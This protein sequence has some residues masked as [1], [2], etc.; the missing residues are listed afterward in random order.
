MMKDIAVVMIHGMGDIKEGF[1]DDMREKL[2]KKLKPEVAKR[3]HYEK[4]YYSDILQEPQE[5]MFASMEVEIHK[6]WYASFCKMIYDCTRSKKRMKRCRDLGFIW[7]MLSVVMSL[8]ISIRFLDVESIQQDGWTYLIFSIHTLRPL[9]IFILSILI[10]LFI[11]PFNRIFILELRK[12]MMYNMSDA[13]ALSSKV[14]Q[15]GKPYYDVQKRVCKALKEA[16]QSLTEK[17]KKV[18][19]VAD[20]L[21]AHVISN[22]I[23]D[24][25]NG[26]G[27]FEAKKYP[28]TSFGTL[29][30]SEEEKFLRL[31]N[32]KSFIT[33]GCNIP[34]LVGAHR[35]IEAIATDSCG[36]NFD[37]YNYYD[38]DDIL[39]WPL[40]C[41]PH[42]CNKGSYDEAVSE[43][44]AINAWRG[45]W[46]L[47]TRSWNP[48]CHLEYWKTEEVVDKIAKEIKAIV[49]GN[50]DNGDSDKSTED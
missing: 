49:N 10:L 39:G 35:N 18:I 16:Y 46:G 9:V 21:G 4:I 47:L 17:E 33:T 2:E 23:W 11:N 6:G 15:E 26:K 42:D 24:C 3:V 44:R 36:Y 8:I 31:Q 13:G 41:I 37:W 14:Y 7:I 28:D 27:I 43:D 12:F 5:K 29:E 22:Y 38:K 25:Q 34:L 50:G 19:L 32:M 20:S 1:G 30:L 45:I 48:L 40:K